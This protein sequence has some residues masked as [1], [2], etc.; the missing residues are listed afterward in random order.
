MKQNKAIIC[1]SISLLVISLAI[2]PASIQ[3]LDS[4]NQNSIRSTDSNASITESQSHPATIEETAP[5]SSTPL[6][7][8]QT[9]TTDKDV[10]PVEKLE[11]S[12]NKSKVAVGETAQISATILPSTT[13]QIVQY[14]VSNPAVVSIDNA[15]Q[16]TG[17]SIG[18][19]EIKVSS[20]DGT[21][22]SSVTI[23]VVKPSVSYQSHIQN[24]GW[25]SFAKDG[26]M[27]GTQGKSL[28][29]EAIKIKLDDVTHSG[30]INYQVH[31]QN[32]G[33]QVVNG[34]PYVSDDAVAGTT[35]Q[36]KRMEAIKITLTDEL[37]AH[38]DIYYRV[39]IQNIGWLSWAKNGEGCGESGDCG[40]FRRY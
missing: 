38:Y 7:S 17:L 34:K 1:L 24:V 22:S 8:G 30:H 16:V 2:C 9:P 20:Q 5:T 25:Q 29:L 13:S 31:I 39:H 6:T 37:V 23:T 18:V 28:R 14:Q 33:W 40:T 21:V 3:A 19:A 15:G 26:A 27:S 10:M 4:T 35:G 11:V 36:A 32:V 12:I